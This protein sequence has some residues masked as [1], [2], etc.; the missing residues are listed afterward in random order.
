MNCKVVFIFSDA[1]GLQ[2]A[3]H[4]CKLLH[5]KRWTKCL[6]SVIKRVFDYLTSLTHICKL[7]FPFSPPKPLQQIQPQPKSKVGNTNLIDDKKK[8][9]FNL[10]IDLSLGFNR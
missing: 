3:D 8:E 4:V 7:F 1:K 2:S 5:E 10:N 6:R 9:I